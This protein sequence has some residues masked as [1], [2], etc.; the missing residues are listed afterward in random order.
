MPTGD[1]PFE[2]HL[3][4]LCPIYDPNRDGDLDTSVIS[5]TS[6]E[7]NDLSSDI[8]SLTV[9]DNKEGNL[10]GSGGT[11]EGLDNDDDADDSSA[12]SSFADLLPANLSGGGNTHNHNNNNNNTNTTND[13]KHRK[14]SPPPTG[15]TPTPRSPQPPEIQLHLL[16]NFR[17]EGS[18]TQLHISHDHTLTFFKLQQII[19]SG[20]AV[21]DRVPDARHKDMIVMNIMCSAAPPSSSPQHQVPWEI[22]MSEGAMRRFLTEV[23]RRMT[24]GGVKGRR[25]AG[26]CLC[27]C[28][29]GEEA[30]V[31]DGQWIA[32]VE[33]KIKTFVA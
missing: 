29:C 21:F 22:I 31:A 6:W 16:I 27:P 20:L 24:K 11:V 23:I 14:T 33:I 1:E 32:K 2:D 30:M 3:R 7:E 18:F 28:G 10:A 9:D 17:S 26:G 25:G 8:I 12:S 13:N 4:R 5:S 15:T 19:S